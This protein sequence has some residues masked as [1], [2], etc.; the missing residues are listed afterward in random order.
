LKRERT[1]EEDENKRT[2]KGTKLSSRESG[3][4]GAL[5]Q[6]TLEAEK[7]PL[8]K[9][10][11]HVA[12]KELRSELLQLAAVVPVE[13][14][15]DFVTS[16]ALL[17]EGMPEKEGKLALLQ[18][19]REIVHNINSVSLE[20]RKSIVD[21]IKRAVPL[22]HWQDLTHNIGVREFVMVVSVIPMGQR[23][24]V[25]LSWAKL[26]LRHVNR[27]TAESILSQIVHM[28]EEQQKN[29]LQH[30]VNIQTTLSGGGMSIVD[31]LEGLSTEGIERLITAIEWLL[32]GENIDIRPEL[33]AA[34]SWVRP[35][36][37]LELLGQVQ[38]LANQSNKLSIIKFLTD[39]SA[40]QIQDIKE[41]TESY[42]RGAPATLQEKAKVYLTLAKIGVSKNLIFG[43]S[44]NRDATD[45]RR[46][47]IAMAEKL[48]DGSEGYADKIGILEAVVAITPNQRA[49]VLLQAGPWLKGSSGKEKA[50]IILSIAKLEPDQR[51]ATLAAAAAWEPKEG[52][53]KSE[54][55]RGF[56]YINLAQ[57]EDIKLQAR[58]FYEDVESNSEKFKIFQIIAN[59]IRQENR[60]ALLSYV[61]PLLKES[62]GCD[63]IELL[64]KFRNFW[65]E[66]LEEIAKKAGPFL[67]DANPKC[68]GHIF[69]AIAH[70]PD[71]ERDAVLTDVRPWIQGITDIERANAIQL[72]ADVP[73]HRRAV[74]LARVSRLAQGVE[75]PQTR[76]QLLKNNAQRVCFPEGYDSVYKMDVARESLKN[77][78]LQLLRTISEM[79]NKESAY[80]LRIH[81]MNEP[82]ID[83]GG[84]GKE[85]ISEIFEGIKTKMR[86][87]EYSNGLYRPI[88][89]MKNYEYQPLSNEEKQH[90]YQ[91]GQLMMFCLNAERE[92]PIGMLFD[93]ALFTML[94]KLQPKHFEKS[95][96]ELI[97]NQEGFTELFAIY[98]AMN[99]DNEDDMRSLNIMKSYLASEETREQTIETIQSIMKPI[100]VP[101]IE[102]ARGMKAAPFSAITWDDIQA[103]RPSLLSELLQGKVTRE[104]IIE[105]LEF[106]ESIPEDKQQWMKEWINQADFAKVQRFLF[107]LTGAR[108]LGNKGL[109]IEPSSENVHFHTCTNTVELPLAAISSQ[110][111]FDEFMELALTGTEKY[112]K[113]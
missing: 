44:V 7:S 29:I 4:T 30:V 35:D 31:L 43:T 74:L 22:Y 49:D 6:K 99:S 23:N 98:E 83:A 94:T 50:D 38:S 93:Q 86:F 69:L 18:C 111:E 112:S 37:R 75:S 63:R 60:A 52:I 2:L 65:P 77:D 15:V 100:M 84:L 13:Q 16:M 96:D 66:D 24:E 64:P 12:D 80:E 36:Q 71:D 3:K 79:M 113:G 14:K 82:G 5:A 9:A 21:A 106:D 34:V 108:A 105:K 8:E 72:L 95:F 39:N 68:K 48:L 70:I 102:I 107:A 62:S 47:V 11:E 33:L 88:L 103:M 27:E 58:P 41:S 81:F 109:T 101:I 92:Y 61:L 17:L 20:Q 46:A 89:P 10:S 42:L 56:Q 54:L 59:A 32:Q 67:E 40:Q 110:Q 1:E 57:M 19:V 25:Q 104:M 26:L 85:F 73:V 97:A 45:Q 90:Y 55:I 87:K 78:P 91:L 51:A 76:L 53:S 28:P